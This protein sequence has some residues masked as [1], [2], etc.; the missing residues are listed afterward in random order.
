MQD[1]EEK[2]KKM[3]KWKKKKIGEKENRKMQS[4]ERER[5]V[6]LYY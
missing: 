6:C 5:R 2:G 4:R 1:G 3:E